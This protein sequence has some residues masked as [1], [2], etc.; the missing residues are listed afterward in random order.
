MFLLCVCRTPISINRYLHKK[1]FGIDWNVSLLAFLGCSAGQ[2]FLS[3][4]DIWDRGTGRNQIQQAGSYG[5]CAT[6]SCSCCHDY[7][8]QTGKIFLVYT[9]RYKIKF[10]KNK[11][12]Y[13]YRMS[14]DAAAAA[15]ETEPEPNSTSK[16]KVKKWKFTLKNNINAPKCSV[17]T[18]LAQDAFTDVWH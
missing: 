9:H 16:N 8:L 17:Q 12:I 10:K 3:E 13:I 14:S 11:H 5:K 18:V 4:R 15:A 1:V 6:L 7:R 2:T